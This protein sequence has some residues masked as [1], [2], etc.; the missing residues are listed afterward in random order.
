MNEKKLE[1]VARAICRAAGTET[2]DGKTCAF[3]EGEY[4][5][6]CMWKSF[7]KEAEAALK[8]AKGFKT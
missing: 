7:L 1:R 3:C 6:P 4:P 2:S 5:E 8:A